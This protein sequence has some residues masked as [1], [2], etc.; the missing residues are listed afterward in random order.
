MEAYL[1]Q[2]GGSAAVP[3]EGF[4]SQEVP[5]PAPAAADA[6][7][8]ADE[9]NKKLVGRPGAPLVLHVQGDEASAPAHVARYVGKSFHRLN[10][11]AALDLPGI[12]AIGLGELTAPQ[13]SARLEA[14]PEFEGFTVQAQLLPFESDDPNALPR[15]GMR[16]F[17]M[18]SGRSANRTGKVPAEY[19]IAAGDSIRVQ[20]FG[21]EN[22]FYTLPVDDEGRLTVP[23]VG[24]VVVA[25]LS[26]AQVREELKTRIEQQMI[27]VQAS[28]TM[29][30]LRSIEVTVLGE[31]QQPGTV[32]VDA[33]ARVADAISAADGVLPSAS[34]RRIELRRAGEGVQVFDTYDALLRGVTG[35]NLRLRS[36]DT[37]FVPTH[38][39]L[40]SV[41]GAVVR[42]GIYELRYGGTI[43]DVL[44]LA[45]GPK[46]EANRSELTLTRQMGESVPT[47]M[48]L[49]WQQRQLNAVPA[50]SGDVLRVHTAPADV[51][52]GVEVYGPVLRS[53]AYGWSSGMRLSDLLPGPEAFKPGAVTD[54]VVIW[55]RPPA[56]EQHEVVFADMNVIWQQGAEAPRL[57]AGDRVYTFDENDERDEVLADVVAA[58]RQQATPAQPEQVVTVTGPVRFPGEYPFATGA[59]VTDLV[60]AAGGLSQAAMRDQLA[61]TRYQFDS[62]SGERQ[63]EFEGNIPL[64][65]VGAGLAIQPFDVISVRVKPGWS[66]LEFVTIEGEV[67]FPGRYP[68]HKGMTLRQAVAQAGGLTDFAYPQGAVFMREQLRER[69]QAQIDRLEKRL[70]GELA[71]VSLQAAQGGGESDAQSAIALLNQIE[72]SEALGRLVIDLPAALSEQADYQVTVRGGDRLVVPIQPQTVSVIGEVNYPTSHLYDRDKN[73][74][75]F[76]AQSGGLTRYADK[77]RIYVV[78][79]NGEVAVPSGF[80]SKRIELLP[81]DTV[82]V[83]MDV[84]KMRPLELWTS[85]TQI[86][87]QLGLTAAAFNAIGAF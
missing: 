21:K 72:S 45:G 75:A 73:L 68:V 61:L 49:G 67:L 22:R 26:F 83:P 5:K 20:L 2:Q 74:G 30:R 7:P 79:A 52:L 42:P 35:G 47:R 4:A 3:S 58:L 40:I 18:P 81:G 24:P 62:V 54:F 65:A 69:E 76:L 82:V 70:R 46:P 34:L 53:G 16:L 39:E 86:I 23:G 77:G 50:R 29:G 1:K 36:G 44:Q 28:I 17:E 38:G 19:V 78:R 14:V 31:V 25:G 66:D 64:D 33:F 43:W 63:V 27:G 57:Q 51:A 41:V 80:F 9:R 71:R 32:I 59:T 8:D 37:I 11:N 12:G 10:R 84:T 6:K 13:I 60:R 85:V 87:Y 56:A 15:I 55:R 48:S